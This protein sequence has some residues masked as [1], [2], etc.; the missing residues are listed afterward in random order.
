MVKIFAA[1]FTIKLWY[2]GFAW[3]GLGSGGS[4]GGGTTR[5]ASVKLPETSPMSKRANASQLQEA[6]AAGQG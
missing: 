3:E 1:V 2:V 5:V 4:V 6:L